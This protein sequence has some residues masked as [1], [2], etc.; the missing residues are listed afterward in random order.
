M[1]AYLDNAYRWH[2]EALINR[3]RLALV[4]DA[5]VKAWITEQHTMFDR[6]AQR[7]TKTDLA[8]I[9]AVDKEFLESIN[10]LIDNDELRMFADSSAAGEKPR[11][12][13]EKALHQELEVVQRC[14]LAIQ[15]FRRGLQGLLDI[16]LNDKGTQY[17][18]FQE[19]IYTITAYMMDDVVKQAIE[20]AEKNIS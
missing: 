17:K 8:A 7:R 11:N 20:N 12:V 5:R 18:T 15:D 4:D 2:K 9:G 13:R 3:A 14:I 1:Y 19:A 16:S 10:C 6:Y